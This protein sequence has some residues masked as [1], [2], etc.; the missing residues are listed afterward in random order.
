MPAAAAATSTTA[1][2]S[3]SASLALFHDYVYLYGTHEAE[4]GESD[5]VS[6]RK[7]GES[8]LWTAGGKLQRMMMIMA[9][10][11][12]MAERQAPTCDGK[13][14]QLPWA[15]LKMYMPYI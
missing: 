9:V 5:Q 14:S 11:M 3:A 8:S 2:A 10:L 1:S 7:L 4:K 15:L 6:G 12:I 13:F